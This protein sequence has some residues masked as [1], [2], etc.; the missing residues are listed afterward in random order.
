MQVTCDAKMRQ[1]EELALNNF[2]MHLSRVQ[3]DGVLWL[4]FLGLL[5]ILLQILFALSFVIPHPQTMM[6]QHFIG[7]FAYIDSDLLLQTFLQLPYSF[8][9]IG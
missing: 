9:E 6:Y 8:V 3:Q 4:L 1:S 2:A 5:Q 7:Q